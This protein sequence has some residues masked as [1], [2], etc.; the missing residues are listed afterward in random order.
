V[1][2]VLALTGSE[3]VLIVHSQ[4]GLDEI[5]ISAPTD[6]LELKNGRITS[7]T[8]DTNKLD[9]KQYPAGALAG[10]EA[11]E[12]LRILRSVLAGDP[13]AY[14]DV[15]LL[16]AAAIVYV[17]GKVSEIEEGIAAAAEA[18]DSGRAREK[19]DTWVKRT[20]E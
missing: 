7:G 16:N 5:S 12:N 1:A 4:D 20:G 9:L 14:R 10:G 2:E 15:V 6:Y 19:L 18:I 11:V 13:G 17:A 3:H 8:L